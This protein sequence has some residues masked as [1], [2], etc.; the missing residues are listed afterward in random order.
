[1]TP[2]LKIIGLCGFADVGKDTVADLM[3]TH[4]SYRKLAFADALR[5][6][7]MEGYGVELAVLTDRVRKQTPMPELA[8]SRCTDL[9]YIN[10]AL[11]H[12]YDKAGG[13]RV[14]VSDEMVKPRTP[15]E[16]LQL[17]G[18][19]YRRAQ[20]VSYWARKLR[21]TVRYF[22]REHERHFVITDV[23]YG[24]EAETVRNLGGVLWQ[25]KRPGRAGE[26]EAAHDSA[27]DGSTFQPD[28]IISNAHDLRH[29]QQLVLGELCA[30]SFNL[31][32]VRLEI[33]A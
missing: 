23:R 8:F 1:M 4:A 33:A 22:M 3:A 7:I 5:A 19:Q 2:K 27:V 25:I 9:A 21:E 31:P 14:V 15:R 18:T 20:D 13:A 17:W 10:A 12:L 28:R 6:E 30:Y 32:A 29:L 16:T 26:L 24:N 11:R